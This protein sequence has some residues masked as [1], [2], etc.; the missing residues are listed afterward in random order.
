[1]SVSTVHGRVLDRPGHSPSDLFL[2]NR[3]SM[4]T[5][6]TQEVITFY[7]ATAAITVDGTLPAAAL[8]RIIVRIRNLS[9]ATLTSPANL[10]FNLATG[11]VFSA[12][13]YSY[14]GW[15]QS[16]L[17]TTTGLQQGLNNGATSFK[18]NGPITA[19][20]TS[21]QSS[22]A[23]GAKGVNI[24]L[25]LENPGATGIPFFSW[26]LWGVGTASGILSTRGHGFMNQV[27]PINGILMGTVG[28]TNMDGGQIEVW[29]QKFTRAE[30][31]LNF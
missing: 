22:T 27:G 10:E 2:L 12:A 1:M 18:M 7:G 14:V 21:I 4:G 20:M 6:T 31:E 30:P 23:T 19:T 26:E 8:A 3:F 17:A 15:G 28:G 9:F 13:G 16:T 29:A 5:A 24:E 11:F 25:I